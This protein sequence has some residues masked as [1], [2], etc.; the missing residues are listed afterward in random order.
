MMR[1]TIRT[2]RRIPDSDVPEFIAQCIET[3]SKIMPPETAKKLWTTVRDRGYVSATDK[4]G[5]GSVTTI[6]TLSPDGE[7]DG[8]SRGA[9]GS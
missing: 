7:D 1:L 2:I 9:P 3:H 4:D 6:Y 8:I 5:D